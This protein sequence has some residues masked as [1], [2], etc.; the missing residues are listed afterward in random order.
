M[1]PATVAYLAATARACTCCWARRLRVA[2][3]TGI[4]EV[5]PRWKW[6]CSS[7]TCAGEAGVPDLSQGV[8]P[9]RPVAPE[10]TCG[11]PAG[12]AWLWSWARDGVSPTALTAAT[13]APAVRTAA[14]GRARRAPCSRDGRMRTRTDPSTI[15][16]SNTED[17]T[18]ATPTASTV[19]P[20][21]TRGRPV[22]LDSAQM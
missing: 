18:S 14:A 10:W 15:R 21:G 11:A 1:A 9:V 7:V 16:H 8:V 6:P 13:T 19:E 4:C 2:A 17:V 20:W 12:A 3:S 5:G 22:V